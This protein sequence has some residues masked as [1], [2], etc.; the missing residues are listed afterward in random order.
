MNA[1]IQKR[2]KAEENAVCDASD[3]EGC[4]FDEDFHVGVKRNLCE[5][6]SHFRAK[7]DDGRESKYENGL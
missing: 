5:N 3:G 6:I 7:R 1:S 2:K 4:A